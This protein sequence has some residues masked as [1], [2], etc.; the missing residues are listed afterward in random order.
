MIKLAL[1]SQD[2][3]AILSRFESAVEGRTAADNRYATMSTKF[4]DA[5]EKLTKQSFEIAELKAQVERLQTITGSN[6]I[7]G[8]AMANKIGLAMKE[9]ASGNKIAAIKI[10]RE[11]TGCGLKEAKDAVEIADPVYPAANGAGRW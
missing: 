7:V 6:P 8:V 11:L 2:L 10:V 9:R 1:D 3:N 4:Y 5:S